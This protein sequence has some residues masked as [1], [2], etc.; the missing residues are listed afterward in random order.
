MCTLG[1]GLFNRTV[2]HLVRKIEIS[3]LIAILKHSNVL[4]LLLPLQ[5]V[6]PMIM[7]KKYSYFL[8]TGKKVEPS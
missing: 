4:C 5:I 2:A 1:N 7:G 6:L 3:I 8:F